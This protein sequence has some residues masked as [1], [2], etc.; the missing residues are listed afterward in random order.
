M[1][2]RLVLPGSPLVNRG[3]YRW[4]HHPNYV[5]VVAEIAVLALALRAWATLAVGLALQVCVLTI[6]LRVEELALRPLRPG[7]ARAEGSCSAGRPAPG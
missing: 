3:P 1:A 6:R 4:L 2:G 5:I 7:R